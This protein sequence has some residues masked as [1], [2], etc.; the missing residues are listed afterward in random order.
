[1]AGRQRNV[2][3]P[4]GQTAQMGHIRF[5]LLQY[6]T[7]A[8]QRLHGLVSARDRQL[9]GKAFHQSGPRAVPHAHIVGIR[10]AYPE[11]HAPGQENLRSGCRLTEFRQISIR[12]DEIEPVPLRRAHIGTCPDR[13]GPLSVPNDGYAVFA[14]GNIQGETS[15]ENDLTPESAVPL[16]LMIQHPSVCSKQGKITRDRIGMVFLQ[17]GV[18]SEST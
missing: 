6:I 14:F 7:V 17:L 2:D 10:G 15:A 16:P 4:V 13:N 18:R 3:L 11:F 9:A 5:L 8:V 12:V 1:M